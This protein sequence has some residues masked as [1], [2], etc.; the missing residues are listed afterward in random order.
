MMNKQP[1]PNKSATLFQFML[2]AQQIAHQEQGTDK[3]Y[4]M[5]MTSLLS[6]V[7][8]S[9]LA[10]YMTMT[11]MSKASTNA[12]VDGSNT[13]YASESGLNRRAEQLRQKFVGYAPPSSG[14]MVAPPTNMSECFPLPLSTTTSTTSNDF[15]CRNYAFRY[16]NNSAGV[17]SSSNQN[18]MGA[19]NEISNNNT[20]VDYTAFT[21]VADR[22]NY[23][24]TSTVRAP[25][26]AV[27]PAGETYAGLNAQEYKY[28]VYA[29]AAKP[30]PTNIAQPV[31][32][33]DAKTVLEMAFKSR[34]IPLFQFAAFYDGD[35]EMNSSSNMTLSGWVHSNANIYVQPLT[36]SS[37]ISTTFL[38]KV[39]TAGSIYNRVDASSI[40][41]TSGV[42]RVLMTGSDCTIPANCRSFTA[43]SA[44]YTLPVSAPDITAFAG[45]VKDGNAGAI[46][47][48]TPP[49]GFLRKRNYF[50]NK[51]GEYYAKADMRLEMVPDRDVDTF[52]G[53]VWT[54]DPS[55]SKIPFN[56]TAIRTGGTGTCTTTPPAAGSDPAATYIDPTRQDAST[57]KCNVF[58]KGQLQSLRQPVLVL[59]NANAALQTEENTTLGRALTLPP[60]PN[61]GLIPV[62]LATREKIVRALQVALVSTPSPVKLDQLDLPFT[63]PL[64][65]TFRGEFS[66]LI[67]TITGPALSQG[68]K[69]ALLGASPN[70]IAALSNGWFLPAPIQRIE[71]ANNPTGTPADANNYN[72]RS[73]GFYDGRERRWIT[74]LQTNIASLSV[75]NRDGVYV[76][77]TTALAGIGS[78]DTNLTTVY[79]TNDD[80]RNA[81]F[82]AGAGANFTNGLAFDR[83]A[84]DPTKPVGTLEYLGLGAI[85]RTEG[86]LVLYA[87]VNDDLNGD[88]AI[89]AATDVST[90]SAN[91]ILKKNADGSN[92]IDPSTGT[93]VTLDYPRKYRNGNT[94]QSPFG[95]AFNGGNYLPAPLTLVTD[96]SIY[97]QGNFNNNRSTQ[98]GAGPNTPD[99]DRLPASI[100]GDTITALSNQC[101]NNSTTSVA[102]I[103]NHL[104]VP[105]GQLNCGLPRTATGSVN[106]TVSSNTPTYYPVTGPTAVNAA[107]LS[108]TR[109]SNGNLGAGRGFGTGN[110]Y[111]GGLNNYMRMLED[112]N[113]AQYFN[114]SG[115]FVSLG[116]PL[117]YSGNYIGGGTYYMI[118]VR[119]FN[120]DTKF[121]AFAAMPPLAPRVI[122]LQQDIFKRNY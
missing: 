119:N 93:T 59:K 27:I 106:V 29:T 19:S 31:R 77:A 53:N 3:G 84:A 101:V 47:L 92:Y 35:L 58:T 90:D 122:Y 94:Y 80:M 121:N 76:E 104:G 60:I 95:F 46:T 97:V 112:W 78:P 55:R 68:V 57:L 4:A 115:S 83:A 69:D 11:N 9:L 113:Q 45:K 25:V 2:R 96:Q 15:E 42:T 71:T 20:N 38:S 44:G 67:N 51:V 70:R 1:N 105:V 18:D 22:T 99:P 63:D 30:D 87:T 110:A 43:F 108:Y 109:R 118:P 36:N 16:N 116:T 50:N 39:T 65:A 23:D 100:I 32:S 49:P 12:Y 24:T 120:F 21:F 89:S 56:F 7:L 81:T 114:Y 86:G 5:M 33:N 82:N 14:S 107:F 64:L 91:P 103:T 54:R 66:R 98:P 73:S 62:S 34:I 6:I 74:M 26:P 61:F 75:W 52:T 102:S 8:F 41:S 17:R 40:A 117:E 13:F 48:R 10:A 79:Q 85:D 88:G 111:S 72:Y 28:T 37:A